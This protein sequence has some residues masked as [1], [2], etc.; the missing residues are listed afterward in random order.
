V[1][2]HL[3]KVV[4]S[5]DGPAVIVSWNAAALGG[6]VA[7]A[8][9]VPDD[10]P[11]PSWLSSPRGAI[12]PESLVEDIM[13]CLAA[14][15]GGRWGLVLLAPNSVVEF[16]K[17]CALFGQ[18]ENDAFLRAAGEKAGLGADATLATVFCLTSGSAAGAE[19]MKFPAGQSHARLIFS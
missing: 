19:P 1:D 18:I 14:V 12:T 9:G 5:E 10:V 7:A 8:N 6:F 16:G 3:S 11:T 13:T 2:A 15:A 4:V 17:I